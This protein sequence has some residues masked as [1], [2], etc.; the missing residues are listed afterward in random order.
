LWQTAA[1]WNF[2]LMKYIVSLSLF[3]QLLNPTYSQSNFPTLIKDVFPGSGSSLNNSM[4]ASDDFFA[5]KLGDKIIFRGANSLAVPTDTNSRDYEVFVTDGTNE[6]TNLL[7]DI[8]PTASSYC[9]SFFTFR[10]KVYFHAYTGIGG[11]ESMWSTDGTTAGTNLFKN[12]GFRSYYDNLYYPNIIQ[13]DSLHFIFSGDTTI[14]KSNLYISDGTP[15]GTY[16]LKDFNPTN[17]SSSRAF[18]HPGNFTRVANNKIIFTASTDAL[19]DELYVTD[20]TPAGTLL[21]KNINPGQRDFLTFSDGFTK[22]HSDGQKAYFFANDSIHGAEPWVSDG[23]IE[24]TFMLKD[25]NQGIGGSIKSLTGFTTI[26]GITYFIAK[27]IDNGAEIYRTDGSTAGTSLLVDF[28]VGP[29]PG[30]G[31][32]L[33]SMGNKLIFAGTNDGQEV[34]IFSYDVTTN[35]AEKLVFLSNNPPGN[36]TSITSPTLLNSN[37]HCDQLYF[38]ILNMTNFTGS[39]NYNIGVTDG[40]VSGSG[41]LLDTNSNANSGFIRMGFWEPS[42]IELNG[43]LVFMGNNG[44]TGLELYK[45]PLCT[46]NNTVINNIQKQV[47][48]DESAITVYPNPSN[49]TINIDFPDWTSEISLTII[50]AFGETVSKEVIVGS[51]TTFQ[52]QL[53]AGLYFLTFNNKD[54]VITKKL[55][56]L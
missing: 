50:N 23:T 18:A 46:G 29:L 45:I 12:I 56:V 11:T 40:T 53:S 35:N 20:G 8:N 38:D 42:L 7:K 2:A 9:R 26:A 43:S 24:G 25:I 28:N 13:H 52:K 30:I 27:T 49:G 3:L 55:I 19:G 15:Q 32:Y 21:L 54:A 44:Q 33:V 37:I 17:I 16:S 4:F 47:S 14:V 48:K 10:D 39:F 6:G 1:S 51:T 5:A 36:L 34:N 41:L 31:D 22:F